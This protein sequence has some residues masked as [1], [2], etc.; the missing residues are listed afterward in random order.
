MVEVSV[1]RLGVLTSD[2]TAAFLRTCTHYQA[3]G[4]RVTLGSSNVL[5]A[6]GTFRG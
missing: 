2:R 5:L 1:T 3:T 6:K 4:A